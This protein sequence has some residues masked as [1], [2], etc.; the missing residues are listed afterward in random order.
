MI[1]RYIKW[2][3][4]IYKNDYW[5]N[6]I[7]ARLKIFIHKGTI[8]QKESS[9]EIKRDCTSW[10]VLPCIPILNEFKR[11]SKNFNT[12]LVFTSLNK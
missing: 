3:M 11:I 10:F 5:F 6:T 12:K 7:N 4:M 9:E 2:Y 8:Q 1:I